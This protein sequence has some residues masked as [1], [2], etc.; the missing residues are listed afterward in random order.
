MSFCQLAY[1]KNTYRLHDILSYTLTDH[2][3]VDCLTT[4][5]CYALFCGWR[6]VCP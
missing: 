2:S 6:H 4:L 1:L 5:Q 3:L